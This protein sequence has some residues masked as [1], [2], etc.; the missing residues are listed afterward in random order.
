[1]QVQL[2]YSPLR[3]GLMMVPTALAGILTKSWIS[4]LV[5]RFGYDKFLLVNTVIVAASIMSFALISKGWPVWVQVVPLALFGGANS[6]Q[7]AAMNSVTLKDLRIEDA[8]S[9]NSL[10]S[11][12]QM[13]ALG[14][15]AT[16]G[17]GLLNLLSDEFQSTALAF[18]W[19]F[20]AV[21]AITLVSAALFR[22]LEN[23]ELEPSVAKQP[24]LDKRSSPLTDG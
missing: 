10:F 14:F 12:V 21:G 6:M 3:S 19:T 9:G 16:I 17:G 2:G 11:M 7:F 8:G 20:V 24:P 18:R 5:R 23:S 15:G 1:M 4:R 13:L 22:W